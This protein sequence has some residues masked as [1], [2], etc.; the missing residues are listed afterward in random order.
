MRM[1]TALR[2]CGWSFVTIAMV[3]TAFAGKG[4]AQA[5]QEASTPA[6]Q[7]KAAADKKRKVADT[8]SLSGEPKE[9]S[10]TTFSGLAKNLVADQKGIWSAPGRVRFEDTVWL[11]PLAGATAGLFVTDRQVSAHLAA[12]SRTQQHY[13]RI[14]TAG[15]GGLVGGGG[16]PAVVR[17]GSR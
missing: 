16:G 10:S 17:T 3:S 1:R 12:D 8:Q 6:A 13:R 15:A 11:V 4:S 14:G 7:S 5:K 9:V 2:K